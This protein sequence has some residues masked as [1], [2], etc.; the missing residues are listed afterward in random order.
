MLGRIYDDSA[1]DLFSD[2]GFAVKQHGKIMIQ[3]LAL[4][5]G[6]RVFG[7]SDIRSSLASDALYAAGWNQS[8]PVVWGDSLKPTR[9]AATSQADD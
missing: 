2:G 1:S 7:F 8:L 3:P 4:Y 6:R 9:P 5:K